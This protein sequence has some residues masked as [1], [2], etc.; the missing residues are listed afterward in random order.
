M[1]QV[2]KWIDGVAPDQAVSEV[3][4]VALKGRLKTVRHFSQLV[5]EKPKEDI[6]FVHQLRVATRRASAALDLFSDL[7][8]KSE[9]RWL[10]KE[11]KRI[12][13]A[14][15][16]ARDLDVLGYRMAELA[17]TK[18]NRRLRPVVKRIVH[19]RQSIQSSLVKSVRSATGKK[20]KR[21][22]R[23][24]VEGV[25]QQHEGARTFETSARMRIRP[26]IEDFFR[27]AEGDFSDSTALHQFRI[28]G[29]KLRYCME[30]LAA[31]FDSSFRD[32]L[33]PTLESIQDE[34]GLIQDHV[35][36]IS[37]L[38]GWISDN[39]ISD[40]DDAACRLK[41]LIS[42]EEEN[43]AIES[44]AFRAKWTAE[45]RMELRRS[46]ADVL[47]GGILDC[48]GEETL[49]CPT[50]LLPLQGVFTASQLGRIDG[51]GD[52]L[53]ENEIPENA[54]R[55]I[56]RKFLVRCLPRALESRPSAD[57]LQGY[58]A[59][60][61]SGREIRL[62]RKSNKFFQTIKSAGDLTRSECEVELTKEQ[63]EKLWPATDGRR[64]EKSRYEIVE[65]DLKIELD[66]YR[67]RLSGLM[68]AEVEF[69][70]ETVSRSFSP[71]EWLGEEVTYDA[72]YKN[73]NLAV[74]S[75]PMT[76]NYDR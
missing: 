41:S 71:P 42:K 37:L 53:G 36:A 33:Y 44:Q 57:I 48:G 52:T 59:M 7:Y 21:R 50:R 55:E 10:R 61:A 12:R 5:T 65:G 20:F 28:S 43:Y 13:S 16:R 1:V 9:K 69:P 8:P 4:T 64:V 38:R 51:N 32:E 40:N 73:K 2:N 30:L 35:S 25:R 24:L 54:K 29:K 67:G 72:G 23:K 31:A 70:S 26:I 60:E 19:C 27:S 11:L 63:F 68:T 62:R 74:H 49:L 46:F 14:A 58:L 76:K 56:E 34:L 39:S 15:G 45:R 66:V 6:E 75:N 47:A 22:C 18:E 3:A 17:K